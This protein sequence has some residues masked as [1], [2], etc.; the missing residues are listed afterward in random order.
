M[1]AHLTK[2][3][4]SLSRVVLTK[5]LDA[6]NGDDSAAALVTAA[7]N[8]LDYR[9]NEAAAIQLLSSII[10]HDDLAEAINGSL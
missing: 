5:L 10:L 1:M 6:S 8:A 3:S 4:F 7:L 9:Q 2:H